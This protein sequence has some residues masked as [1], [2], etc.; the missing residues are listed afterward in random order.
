MKDDMKLTFAKEGE[1]AAQG[2]SGRM[3]YFKR[4]WPIF[5]SYGEQGGRIQKGVWLSFDLG[6]RVYRVS[7]CW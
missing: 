6:E 3:F 4:L 2:K 5:F 7:W 1:L